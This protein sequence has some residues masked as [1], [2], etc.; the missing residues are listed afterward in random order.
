MKI[1]NDSDD[2]YYDGPMYQ[3]PTLD[4]L[5]N[6]KWT[7]GN[8]YWLFLICEWL[9]FIHKRGQMCILLAWFFFV[10]GQTQVRDVQSDTNH[11]CIGGHMLLHS[12]HSLD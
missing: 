4:P 3:D 12:C 5:L 6:V 8:L 9:V 11:Y 7:Q 10:Q 1:Q 2:Q